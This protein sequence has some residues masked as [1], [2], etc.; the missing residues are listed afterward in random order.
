MTEQDHSFGKALF[1]RRWRS[2]A[3]VFDW[4]RK[5]WRQ[6]LPSGRDANR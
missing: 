5:T 1:G 6:A 4:F 2:I 3:P